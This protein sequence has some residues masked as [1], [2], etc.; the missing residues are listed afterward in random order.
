MVVEEATSRYLAAMDKALPGFI[1]MLFVTGSVALG[2]FEPGV[3]DI[4]TVIVTARKPGPDDLAAMAAVHAVMPER[5]HF[6]GIYLDRLTFTQ[7]PAD[8]PVVP[9]VVNGHFQTDGPCGDLNPVLWLVLSRYGVA[10][11]GPAV[12]DLGLVVDLEAL[13]RF[14]LENLQTYWAP[15]ADKVRQALSGVP[16]DVPADATEVNAEGIA[17]CALG[18]AR[19]HF[20]LANRDVIS[21]AGSGAYLAEHFPAYALLADRA[22][23]WRRGE[24]MVFTAADARAAADS[25][26]AI[27]VDACQRWA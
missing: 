19:L 9:F 5:P 11:R 17:W 25:I 15:L 24:S 8:R 20:T 22:V 10:V 4:D 26:D 6:D 13:R 14:N 16:D 2:A 21:K 1:D 12:P 27:V 3:S 18:P 23:R 7:Q